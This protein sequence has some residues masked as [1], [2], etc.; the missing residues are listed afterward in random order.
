MYF[1][2]GRHD[3]MTSSAIAAAYF[4]QIEAPKKGLYWIKNAGHLVDTDN[5]ADFFAAV[6]NILDSCKK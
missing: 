5:P 6:K 1:I 4:N 3:E 2:L